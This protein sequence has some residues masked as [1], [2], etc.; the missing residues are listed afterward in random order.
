[1]K[2]VLDGLLKYILTKSNPLAVYLFG[3]L[4]QDQYTDVS[5]IDLALVYASKVELKSAKKQILNNRPF[6]DVAIDFLF[7]TDEEFQQ[8]SQRGGVCQ[9]I[10]EDGE[11]LYQGQKNVASKPR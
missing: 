4:A 1:M 8:K 7:F 11:I 9:I 2:P 6:L 5:D 3:S 10:H